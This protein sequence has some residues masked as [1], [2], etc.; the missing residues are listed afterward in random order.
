MKKVLLLVLMCFS[1]SVYADRFKS[2]AF[3][4]AIVINGQYIW[5]NWE[6]SD[7][8]ISVTSE[9]VVIFSPYVQVYKI[10]YKY[11]NG[12]Y[13]YDPKG[14]KYI[15]VKI[16]DQDGDIGEMRFRITKKGEAQ[17]YID[18]NNIAWVY[19]VI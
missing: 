10:I 12:E 3:C 9:G 6:P 11:N 15:K 17:I 1:L 19:N 2:T 4:Q 5:G 13:Y 8:I 16:K 7:I 14:G 18:F